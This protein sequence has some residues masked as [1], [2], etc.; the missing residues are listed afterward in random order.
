M[1][2]FERNTDVHKVGE[3]LRADNLWSAQ[4]PAVELCVQERPKVTSFTEY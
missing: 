3:P 2:F 4:L 1:Q